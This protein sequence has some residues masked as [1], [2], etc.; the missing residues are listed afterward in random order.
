M[1]PLSISVSVLTILSSLNVGLRHIKLLRD[2]PREIDDV[3]KEIHDFELVTRVVSHALTTRESSLPGD[4]VTSIAT[5]L[6]RAQ[7]ELLQL[8][9]VFKDDLVV[10]IPG[11]EKPKYR[12]L[13]WSK[14]NSKIDGIRKRLLNIKSDLSTSLTASIS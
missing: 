9:H 4:T 13:G 8:Q 11:T 10:A 7:D 6:S 3:A 2:A 1:D 14:R 5:L 12:R